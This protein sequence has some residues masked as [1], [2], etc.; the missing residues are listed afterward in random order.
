VGAATRFLGP[1]QV[2][3]PEDGIGLKVYVL[4]PPRSERRLFKDL[5]TGEGEAR[6][7]YLSSVDEA[8]AVA[9]VAFTHLHGLAMADGLALEDG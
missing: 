1:G 3:A 7:V 6:E 5:P 8:A 9:G 4:A 2:I